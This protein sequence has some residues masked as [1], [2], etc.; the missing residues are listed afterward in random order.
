MR[1]DAE[2][3]ELMNNFLSFFLLFSCIPRFKNNFTIQNVRAAA[4]RFKNGCN[5]RT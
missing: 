1:R 5:Y 4:V 3:F 2:L